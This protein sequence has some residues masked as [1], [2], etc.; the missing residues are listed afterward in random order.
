MN[1]IEIQYHKTKIWELILGSFE[2]KVCL[3]DF[4]YR[5]TRESVDKRLKKWLDA[6]YIEKDNKNL[7]E[8]RKQIDE[9]LIGERK[10]FNI[11]ILMVWTEFQKTVWEALMKIK[12]GTTA[13][14]LDLAKIIWNKKAVRA[15]ANANGANAIALI[16]PCHRI[17]GNNGKLVWYAG[18]LEVK[19]TLLNLENNIEFL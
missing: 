7:Q 11:P 10:T 12:Y 17:I 15:V 2:N 1:Q 5:K 4:R 9:Y 13:S 16:I 3:V 8:T 14:Y 19:K 18:G 6:E